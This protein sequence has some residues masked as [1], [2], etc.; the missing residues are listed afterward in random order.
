MN[1]R[2]HSWDDGDCLLACREKDEL[3]EA[4]AARLQQ[5]MSGHVID[6]GGTSN[7]A[8]PA[9]DVLE[10]LRGQLRGA[11]DIIAQLEVRSYPP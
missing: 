1:R 9:D 3:A 2:V 6:E 7:H 10:D 8:E 5:L 11:E 4:L